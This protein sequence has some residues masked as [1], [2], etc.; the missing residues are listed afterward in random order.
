MPITKLKVI[1]KPPASAS[2][3]SLEHG[4][5]FLVGEYSGHDQVCGK[6]GTVLLEGVPYGGAD[7]DFI[8]QCW[9]CK[10]FNEVKQAK[11]RA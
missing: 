5:P 11:L 8:V 3:I 4:Q 6:C 1:P 9:K 10:S 2:V 7:F